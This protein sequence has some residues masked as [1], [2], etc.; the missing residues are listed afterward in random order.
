[1]TEVYK[2]DSGTLKIEDNGWFFITKDDVEY[3]FKPDG[4]PCGSST[5]NPAK[6][7][8]SIEISAPK[9][10]KEQRIQYIGNEKVEYDLKGRIRRIGDKDVYY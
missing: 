9:K 6:F 1:M 10:E 2:T 4:T 3:D 5:S 8:Y 7:D